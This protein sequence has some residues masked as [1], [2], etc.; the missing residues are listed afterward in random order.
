MGQKTEMNFYRRFEDRVSVV[1]SDRPLPPAEAK[2]E[3]EALCRA[4][5]EVMAGILKREPTQE[6]LLGLEDISTQ[7][8]K[9][10]SLGKHDVTEITEPSV[11]L[12]RA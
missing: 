1:F 3:N 8:R 5:T 2:A 12:S 9:R 7:R 4:I 11:I 6:E 10:K